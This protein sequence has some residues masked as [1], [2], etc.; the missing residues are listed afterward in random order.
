M[1]AGSSDAE[2]SALLT[3]PERSE[4]VAGKLG[5]WAALYDFRVELKT[6]IGGEMQAVVTAAHACT[7]ESIIVIRAGD[8]PPGPG[9]LLNV[10]RKL[11]QR[12]RT[13]MIDRLRAGGSRRH[14]YPMNI[15][16]EQWPSARPRSQP[17]PELRANSTHWKRGLVTSFSMAMRRTSVSFPE[18]I[19]PFG[20]SSAERTRMI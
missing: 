5:E 1:T 14:P 17:S 16:P 11:R 7:H 10:A 19:S 18:R 13:V 15:C 20:D 9:W 8:V 4:A 3:A 6:C 12:A 2:I